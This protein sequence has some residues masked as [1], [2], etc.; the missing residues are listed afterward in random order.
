MR[1]KSKRVYYKRYEDLSRTQQW[2]RRKAEQL[3]EISKN[4]L[5]SHLESSSPILE[6]KSFVDKRAVPGR[7]R[8]LVKLQLQP[9]QEAEQPCSSRSGITKPV[10]V[11]TNLVQDRTAT[12]CMSGSPLT[13]SSGTSGSPAGLLS[14]SSSSSASSSPLSSFSDSSEM[15]ESAPMDLIVDL[16]NERQQRQFVRKNDPVLDFK[17]GL[18]TWILDNDVPEDAVTDLL[19]ILKPY[20]KHLPSSY[21]DLMNPPKV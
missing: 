8:G 17:N 4:T 11:R 21:K 7:L 5:T 3:D 13:S 10:S 15:S 14:S 19:K 12:S 16:K 18:R 20:K 6:E 9:S 2:R 1:V